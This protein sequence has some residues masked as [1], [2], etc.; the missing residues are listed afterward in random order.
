MMKIAPA[1]ALAIWAIGTIW[2][3]LFGVL[4]HFDQQLG[5]TLVDWIQALSIPPL[6]ALFPIFRRW[7]TGWLSRTKN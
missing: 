3:F 5:E 6:A 7:F 2:L 1:S 4:E